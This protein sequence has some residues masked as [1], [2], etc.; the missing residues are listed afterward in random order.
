MSERRSAVGYLRPALPTVIRVSPL[1]IVVRRW[2]VTWSTYGSEVTPVHSA[3][4]DLV[5]RSAVGGDL[6]QLDNPATQRALSTSVQE[7]D[8]AGEASAPGS[9]ATASGWVTEL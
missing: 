9:W 5:T 8:R 1:R 6:S 4:T 3:L 7:L 2:Y